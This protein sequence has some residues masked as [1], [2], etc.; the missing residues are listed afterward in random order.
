MKRRVNF[1][2]STSHLSS[3]S[4]QLSQ[5]PS[6]CHSPQLSTPLP[7][8]LT[9]SPG[10][11]VG[12]H[13]RQMVVGQFFDGINSSMASTARGPIGK[14]GGG[15]VRSGSPAHF[16]RSATPSDLLRSA[17]PTRDLAAAAAAK[18]VRR[19]SAPG[20]VFQAYVDPMQGKT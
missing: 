16:P 14:L 15:R 2:L 17:T 8:S 13:D 5:H 4:A 10:R 12:P 6:I 7:L 18:S 11:Q 9:G 20:D 3:P 1:Q 19:D